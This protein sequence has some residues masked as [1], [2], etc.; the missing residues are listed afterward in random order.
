M[1]NEKSSEGITEDILTELRQKI[2]ALTKIQKIYWIH[3]LVFNGFVTCL[4]FLSSSAVFTE[5]ISKDIIGGILLSIGVLNTISVLY[6]FESKSNSCKEYSII[7]RGFLYDI[8]EGKKDNMRE[9][10]IDILKT[11]PQYSDCC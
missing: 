3:H 2:K 6:K 4:T 9:R 7:L 5:H 10:Y 1:S 8:E 11:S